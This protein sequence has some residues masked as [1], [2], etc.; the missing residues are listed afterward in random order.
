MEEHKPDAIVPKKGK[1]PHPGCG[2]VGNQKG[3]LCD[4]C[5]IEAHGPDDIEP[6]KGKCGHPACGKLAQRKGGL[7]I[8]HC[9]EAHGI[10]VHGKWG[11]SKKNQELLLKEIDKMGGLTRC[12]KNSRVLMCI[13]DKHQNHLGWKEGCNKTVG[14][15]VCYQKA[16]DLK[17]TFQK[18]CNKLKVS[19]PEGPT[20]QQDNDKEEGE[21]EEKWPKQTV[22]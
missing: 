6:K 5:C 7:C 2:K 14:D 20:N 9:M 22:C 16:L 8:L 18:I 10:A 13:C 17:G 4:E 11:L 19:K 3:H 1:C 15:L 12:N 21:A